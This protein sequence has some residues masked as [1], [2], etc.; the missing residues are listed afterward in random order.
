MILAGCEG[1][2]KFAECSGHLLLKVPAITWADSFSI[3]FAHWGFTS[4][5]SLCLLVNA[6][7]RLRCLLPLQAHQ[8]VPGGLWGCGL[9]CLRLLP[10]EVTFARTEFHWLWPSRLILT[11]RLAASVAYHL[12]FVPCLRRHGPRLRCPGPVLKGKT[13]VKSV[14][15]RPAGPRTVFALPAPDLKLS[16]AFGVLADCYHQAS[17]CSIRAMISQSRIRISPWS[18]PYPACSPQT[19]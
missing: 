11:K 9:S 16:P 19:M 17:S 3:T 2:C 14:H 7:I 5:H 10:M 15:G 12:D 18:S 1:R 4:A 8:G 13:R 6:T